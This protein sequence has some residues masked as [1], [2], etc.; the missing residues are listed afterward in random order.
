MNSFGTIPIFDLSE[1]Q[2]IELEKIMARAYSVLASCAQKHYQFPNIKKLRDEFRQGKI[3]LSTESEAIA[4]LQ[5]MR[6]IEERVIGGFIRLCAFLPKHRI[7][8]K[9]DIVQECV[10]VIYDNMYCFDGRGKFSTF[11]L[12]CMTNR[13]VDC[14]RKELRRIGYFNELKRRYVG[15][16]D[17][18]TMKRKRVGE[19][20]LQLMKEL[21]AQ[22][23]LTDL[24]R[25][26]VVAHLERDL[27]FRSNCTEI[28]PKTNKPYSKAYYSQEFIKACDQLRLAYNKEA[29]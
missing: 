20:R 24:Q 18:V 28:N 25:D 27:H 23:N 1:N 17:N 14:T 9:N 29:A 26:L 4:C 12:F 11:I 16:E 21:I 10:L 6:S 3:D 5:E 7:L 19:E 22:G 2:I 15:E 13:I 8:D